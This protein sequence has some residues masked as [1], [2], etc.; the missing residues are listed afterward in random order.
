MFTFWT[1]MAFLPLTWQPGMQ[2]FHSTVPCLIL[3]SL[4]LH[5]GPPGLFVAELVEAIYQC[6]HKGL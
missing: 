1:L 6:H 4:S 5:S 3:H 2:E